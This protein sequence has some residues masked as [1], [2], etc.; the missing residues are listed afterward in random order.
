MIKNFKLEN[1]V[2]IEVK[3]TVLGLSEING[4]KYVVYTDYFPSDNELGIRLI[5]GKLISEDP[6]EVEKLRKSDQKDI[7]EDFN[8]EFIKSGAKL[9]K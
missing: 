3:Y 5:A 9:K 8:I 4:T 6:F 1:D 2:G 7:I